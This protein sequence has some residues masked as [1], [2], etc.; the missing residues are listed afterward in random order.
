MQLILILFKQK[1]NQ[2]KA[3]ALDYGVDDGDDDDVNSNDEK[4]EKSGHK[5]KEA[6]CF[7]TLKRQNEQKAK[8]G[9]DQRLRC[10]LCN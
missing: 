5:K 2:I 4:E 1:T 7:T 10:T 8:E 9:V 3:A 6:M